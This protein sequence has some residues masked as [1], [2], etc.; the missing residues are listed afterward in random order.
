M[1]SVSH[2]SNVTALMAMRAPIPKTA[3]PRHFRLAEEAYVL[4]AADT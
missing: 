3:L 1:S 2:T 4:G